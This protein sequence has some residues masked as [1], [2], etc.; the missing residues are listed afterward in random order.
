MIG[1]GLGYGVLRRGGWVKLGLP[2][3]PN[4]EPAMNETDWLTCSTCRHM[5]ASRSG[6]QRTKARLSCVPAAG[7]LRI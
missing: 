5:P 3:R 1:S 2:R 7:T 6:D 4:E